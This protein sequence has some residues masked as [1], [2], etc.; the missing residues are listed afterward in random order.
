MPCPCWQHGLCSYTDCRDAL[1]YALRWQARCQAV[2]VDDEDDKRPFKSVLHVCAD[3]AGHT[4]MACQEGA[5]M[6]YS[7]AGPIRTCLSLLEQGVQCLAVEAAAK[8]RFSL[9][10]RPHEKVT[11][12]PIFCSEPVHALRTAVMALHRALRIVLCEHQ[13][14]LGRRRLQSAMPARGRAESRGGRERSWQR[15]P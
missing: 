6:A 3:T 13:E 14:S 10:I 7:A 4:G 15:C 1:P 12:L 8:E 2:Q 5:G 9:L 11:R